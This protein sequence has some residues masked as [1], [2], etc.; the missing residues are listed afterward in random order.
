MVIAVY[1]AATGYNA[2]YFDRFGGIPVF[3][4]IKIK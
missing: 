4:G 1:I 3:D 2:A